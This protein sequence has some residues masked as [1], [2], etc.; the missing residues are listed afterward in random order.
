MHTSFASP[1]IRIEIYKMY[2]HTSLSF[3]EG[4]NETWYFATTFQKNH[5]KMNMRLK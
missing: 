1:Y 5:Q 4:T 3:L 2:I